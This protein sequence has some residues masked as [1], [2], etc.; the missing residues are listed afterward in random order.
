MTNNPSPHNQ[1]EFDARQKRFLEQ[2]E[3][4]DEDVLVV[5]KGHLLIEEALTRIIGKFVFHP[6][7]VDHLRLRFA[8]RVD[9]A[10]SLSID[11]SRNSM[12]ELISALNMLRNEFAHALESPKRTTKTATVRALYLHEVKGMAY[13]AEHKLWPNHLILASAVALSLGFLFSFEEEAE[14]F[15]DFLNKSDR[16]I[17][18]HRYK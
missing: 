4:V 10:R 15:R 16:F 1:V 3:Q 9:L 17:N 5:L 11:E 6:D 18:P 2:M 13:E 12:W 8:Q 14:R 7:L